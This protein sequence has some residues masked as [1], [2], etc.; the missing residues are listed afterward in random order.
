MGEAVRFLPHRAGGGVFAPAPDDTRPIVACLAIILEDMGQAQRAGT[1][2]AA[3]RADIATG[4]AEIQVSARHFGASVPAAGDLI[5]P[6]PAAGFVWRI[7]APPDS[8]GDMLVFQALREA[9]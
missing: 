2:A 4:Q 7:V 8:H 6:V 9:R 3:D 1:R 5:E